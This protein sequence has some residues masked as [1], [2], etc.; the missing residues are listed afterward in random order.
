MASSIFVYGFMHNFVACFLI[1]LLLLKASPALATYGAR[2]GFVLPA[3][4]TI[5][6]FVE[7]AAVIWWRM[8]L[9]SQIVSALYDVLAWLIAGLILTRFL[10]V[11]G[12]KTA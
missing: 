12:N 1:G 8:P 4:V 10:V 6:F 5:A 2:V 11:S 9:I 3:G 7:V